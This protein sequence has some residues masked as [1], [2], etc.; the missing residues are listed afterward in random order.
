MGALVGLR[1]AWRVCVRGVWPTLLAGL[2]PHAGR[3]ARDALAAARVHGPCGAA[4]QAAGA[5]A[6]IRLALVAACK[7]AFRG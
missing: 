1:G 7:A 5:P 3:A 2:P 6:V 4:L